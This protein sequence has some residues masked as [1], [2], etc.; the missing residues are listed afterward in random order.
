MKVRMVFVF[1]VLAVASLAAQTFRGGIVGTVTDSTGASVAGAQ[2]KATNTGT[3]LVRDAVTG[4][5]GDFN[6]PELPLGEYSISVTKEGF[7]TQTATAIHV[8]VGNPERVNVTLTPGQVDQK[9]EVIADVPLVET[10]GNT[11]A[12]PSKHS[13]YRSYPSTGA[14]TPRCW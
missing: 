10:T 2:V 11:L 12:E 1:V 6:F 8:V 7:R 14:T 13:R 5:D 4:S 9:V 3:G